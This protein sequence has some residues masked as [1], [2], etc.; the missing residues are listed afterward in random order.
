MNAYSSDIWDMSMCTLFEYASTSPVARHQVRR[1]LLEVCHLLDLRVISQS[2]P[3]M[4]LFHGTVMRQAYSSLSAGLCNNGQTVSGTLSLGTST[5]HGMLYIYYFSSNDWYYLTSHASWHGWRGIFECDLKARRNKWIVHNFLSKCHDW[6]YCS[7]PLLSVRFWKILLVSHQRY[8]SYLQRAILTSSYGTFFHPEADL[9]Q[10]CWLSSG[11][12]F[13]APATIPHSLRPTSQCALHFWGHS[14]WFVCA[15]MLNSSH[16]LF[17]HYLHRFCYCWWSK[18]S[19]LP[20]INCPSPF[21][22]T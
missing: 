11:E 16:Q 14:R 10:C 17:F 1:H 12:D 4:F 7:P 3:G 6:F 21:F 8:D 19:W 13:T 2:P 20:S 5:A 18:S 15:V 9:S 22:R